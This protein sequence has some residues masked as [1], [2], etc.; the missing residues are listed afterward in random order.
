MTRYA[1]SIIHPNGKE[2]WCEYASKALTV[3]HFN[4]AKEFY[5]EKFGCKVKLIRYEV[6]QR[7]RFNFK[8]IDE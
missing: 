2:E 5:G 4:R 6:A 7:C 3:E 1:Y 8:V